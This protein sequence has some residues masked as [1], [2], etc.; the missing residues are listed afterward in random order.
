MPGNGVNNMVQMI[1][2]LAEMQDRR[3]RLALD[4]QQFEEQKKQFAQ[5]MGFNEKGQQQAAALKLLDGIAQGGIEAHT[6][7]PQ[8]ARLLGFDEQR[9]Q[10][11]ASAAPN[12]SAALQMVQ[13]QTGQFN[14]KQQKAGLNSMPQPM[15]QQAQQ[16]AYLAQ[17]ANT[18]AGGLATSNLQANLANTPASPDLMRRAGE[19]YVMRTATGQDPFSFNVGQAGIDQNLAPQAAAIGAG[20]APSWMNKAQDHYWRGSLQNDAAGIAARGQQ[21]GIDMG[22]YA[23]LMNAAHQISKDLAEGK[24]ANTKLRHHM[25]QQYNSMARVLGIDSMKEEDGP[26]NTGAVKQGVN[27]LKG[28]DYPG[29]IDSTQRDSTQRTSINPMYRPP[30]FY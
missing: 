28:I 23:S 19:G 24:Y 22:S 16:G 30:N 7:A 3:K 10:M 26:M 13:A 14:L 12:A 5:Q 15:Q 6:A 1:T 25:I 27:K 2:A 29:G 9:A 8:L 21:G 11:F 4:Q 17:Q 18:N 20:V